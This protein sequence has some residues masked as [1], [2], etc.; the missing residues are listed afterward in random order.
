MTVWQ[1][2]GSGSVGGQ[3]LTGLPVL[4]QISKELG[5]RSVKYWPFDTNWDGDLKG[6]ILTEIWPSLADYNKVDHPIKDARQVS[7]LGNDLWQKNIQGTIYSEFKKPDQLSEEQS[8]SVLCEEG[9]ILGV[10]CN[11]SDLI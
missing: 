5:S 11:S 6:V 4:N 9:W 1:L 7:A 2:L 3:V 10:K 8:N